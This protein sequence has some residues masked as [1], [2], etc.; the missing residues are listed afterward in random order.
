MFAKK[1]IKTN[2]VINNR[3]QAAKKRQKSVSYVKPNIW[4]FTAPV[5]E[6]AAINKQ[7]SHVSQNEDL[8]TNTP[9]IEQT[10]NK[11]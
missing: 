6:T 2:F 9:L 5:K 4:G 10:D 1:L 8:M 7:E 3:L 11:Q